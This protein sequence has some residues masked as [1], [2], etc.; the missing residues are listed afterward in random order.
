[1]LS[2]FLTRSWNRLSGLLQVSSAVGCQQLL[3]SWLSWTRATVR[4]G[5]V[6]SPICRV[7]KIVLSRHGEQKRDSEWISDQFLIL[8][9]TSRIPFLHLRFAFQRKAAPCNPRVYLANV[10]RECNGVICGGRECVNWAQTAIQYPTRKPLPVGL[11]KKL[12]LSES[13]LFIFRGLPI[14]WLQLDMPAE[15]R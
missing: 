14:S 2:K 8:R 9:P 1:M 3:V 12:S 11:G 5:H 10:I 6:V 7:T 13:L 15:Q 4:E